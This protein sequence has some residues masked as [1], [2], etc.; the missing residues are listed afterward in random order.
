MRELAGVW[1]PITVVANSASFFI[2]VSACAERADRSVGELNMLAKFL[3]HGAVVDFSLCVQNRIGTIRKT[4]SRLAALGQDNN[5][6]WIS[7]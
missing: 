7:V 5:S 1:A 6:N 2:V 4:P 3:P